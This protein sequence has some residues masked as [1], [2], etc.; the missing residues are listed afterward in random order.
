MGEWSRGFRAAYL[1]MA[2]LLFAGSV[3][4]LLGTNMTGYLAGGA[5]GCV[6]WALVLL[7]AFDRW[8]S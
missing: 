7:P 2:G 8:F 6:L 4:A 5:L 3:L 1:L